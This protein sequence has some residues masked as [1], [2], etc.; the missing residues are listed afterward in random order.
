MSPPDI[1]FCSLFHDAA[2]KYAEAR[3][4]YVCSSSAERGD[5]GD[6]DAI[7]DDPA[8]RETSRRYGA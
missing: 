2:S 4:G 7:G 8:G 1:F 6:A 5:P 3:P